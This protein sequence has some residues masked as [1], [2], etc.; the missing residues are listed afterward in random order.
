[1][2]GFSGRHRKLGRLVVADL[3]DQHYVRVLAKARADRVWKRDAFLRFDLDLGEATDPVLHGV[4]DGDDLAV[5]TVDEVEA[6]VERGGFAGAG[7]P[8]D[9][10]EAARFTDALQ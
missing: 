4:F 1:M 7:G 8:G 2:S 9:D 10:D 5:G 6:G 3:A